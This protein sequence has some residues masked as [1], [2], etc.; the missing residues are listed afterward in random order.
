M[1]HKANCFGRLITL[2]G[3]ASRSSLFCVMQDNFFERWLFVQRK[4]WEFLLDYI[5]SYKIRIEA[6]LAIE[7]KF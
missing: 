2:K 6:S 4:S 1:I 5:I 7:A 3:E